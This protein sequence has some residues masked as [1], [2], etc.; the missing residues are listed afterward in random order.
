M[1]GAAAAAEGGEEIVTLGI[2]PER[3]E[4]GYG[5]ICRGEECGVFAGV[6]AH[7]AVRFVEKP[8]YE[9]TI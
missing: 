6:P 9:R 1:A 5:Y 3:P 7:R 2:A 4:T 8:D